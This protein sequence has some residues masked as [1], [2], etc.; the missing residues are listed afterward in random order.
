M[1]HNAPQFIAQTAMDQCDEDY[2]S[3]VVDTLLEELSNENPNN[4]NSLIIIGTFMAECVKYLL[5]SGLAVD[6]EEQVYAGLLEIARQYRQAER[7]S[8]N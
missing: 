1:D 7:N 5:A 2:A 4:A 8:L 3:D 6:S